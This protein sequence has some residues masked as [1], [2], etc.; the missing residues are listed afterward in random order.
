MMQFLLYLPPDQGSSPADDPLAAEALDV[1]QEDLEWLLTSDGA[2]FW[3]VLWA[4][5]NLAPL[6]DS[7][8]RYARCGGA[9]LRGCAA[10]EPARRT[11]VCGMCDMPATR[12]LPKACSLVSLAA[13]PMMTA[14]ANRHPPSWPSAH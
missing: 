12:A 14:T 7:Y 4:G 2:T 3:N 13:G 8:L 10:I 5:S 11:C 9:E 1:I 6:V